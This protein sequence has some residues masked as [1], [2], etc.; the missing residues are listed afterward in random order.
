MY[1]CTKMKLAQIKGKSAQR[2]WT[3]NAGVV[4]VYYRIMYTIYTYLICRLVINK[5]KSKLI[6]LKTLSSIG[7]ACN[8]MM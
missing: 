4:V 3:K 5:T 1:I 7:K 2:F 8:S 6:L